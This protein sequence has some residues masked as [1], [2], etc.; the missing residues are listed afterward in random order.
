MDNDPA[1]VILVASNY[2]SDGAA[3]YLNGTEVKRL[4]LPS[5]PITFTTPATGSA[6]TEGSVELFTIPANLLNVGDNVLAVELHQTAGDQA[7]IVFGLSLLAAAQF[8]CSL[9]THTLPP[10]GPLWLENPR[11][12]PSTSRPL[13]RFLSNGSK[14]ANRFSS[15]QSRSHNQ[16]RSGGGCGHLFCAHQ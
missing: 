10:T 11:P 9:P 3:F 4:R 15:H 1:S 8:P 6:T 7:N 13:P 2:L 5:G 14:M 12:S 16:P